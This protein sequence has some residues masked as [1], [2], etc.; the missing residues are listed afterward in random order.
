MD[1]V[2]D[3]ILR[4]ALALLFLVAAAHKLREP[5]RFRDTLVDFRLI[6]A[7]LGP[8]VATL[9][10][11]A[12]VVTAALLLVEVRRPTGFVAA[13]AL[14]VLYAGAIAI[15]LFRGRRDID[16]GCAGPA[17]RHPLSG[18][19]VARNA[20]IAAV[21]AAACTIATEPRRLVWVDAL[22]VV[23]AVSTMAALYSAVDRMLAQSASRAIT[24]RES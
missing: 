12:E 23:A 15:N 22:T 7:A 9:L 18:A 5:T 10:I 19:L 20:F 4:G 24:W 11:V 14:L 21:A 3:L 13:V 16:C 17:L 6:P 8:S 2:I 1:P